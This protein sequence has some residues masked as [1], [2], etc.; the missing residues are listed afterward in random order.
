[1]IT[2]TR[3]GFEWL[4]VCD[5]LFF[6]GESPGANNELKIAREKGLTIYMKLEEVPECA[7]GDNHTT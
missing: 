7:R 6:I 3:Y 1:M 2:W 4:D 5:A